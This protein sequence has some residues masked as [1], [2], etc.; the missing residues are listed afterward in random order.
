M[1]DAGIPKPHITYGIRPS[2]YCVFDRT[3]LVLQPDKPSRRTCTHSLTHHTTLHY[4]VTEM[5][6]DCVYV[7]AIERM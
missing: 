4:T 1:D 3:G 6:K 2:P 7:S 5:V